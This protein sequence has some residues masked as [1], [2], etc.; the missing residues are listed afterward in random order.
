MVGVKVAAT[1]GIRGNGI[2]R[3]WQQTEGCR[4]T[5]RG[6][7]RQT[8]SKF[9]VT[10]G[11]RDGMKKGGRRK[12]NWIGWQEWNRI[13]LKGLGAAEQRKKEGAKEFGEGAN[14]VMSEGCEIR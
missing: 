7:K 4:K 2:R 13:G 14:R 3:S 12:E 6:R 9:C 8:G 5:A 10:V 11:K 1:M